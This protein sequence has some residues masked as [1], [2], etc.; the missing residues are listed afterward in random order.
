[1]FNYEKLLM[2][3]RGYGAWTLSASTYP[4]GICYHS[5]NALPDGR[6]L[7]MGGSTI[8]GYSSLRTNTYFGTISGDTVTWVAGTNLPAAR[9]SFGCVL[10]FDGRILITG[11]SSQGAGVN[12]VASA[13]CYLGTISGNTITWVTSTALPAAR[14]IS[15]AVLLNDGR[16]MVIGGANSTP[17]IGT[18]SGNTITWSAA[19][20]VPIALPPNAR[21][22]M[23]TQVDGRVTICGVGS[24]SDQTFIGTISGNT[25]TWV[26][27]FGGI[28]GS[29][30]MY[31]R[32]VTRNKGWAGSKYMGNG[33]TPWSEKAPMI[34]PLYWGGGTE[35]MDG[36]LLTVGGTNDFVNHLSTI[37]FGHGF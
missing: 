28:P 2:A 12:G 37:T 3:R 29:T 5:L 13:V 15:S 17:Y 4:L 16:V 36:R 34:G 14:Y 22:C 7:A 11:G 35:L 18:V 30:H 21:I 27:G 24:G 31:L 33:D 6:V 25:I 19:T 8:N 26:E 9:A 20:A 10:L 23:F 1:M 32:S